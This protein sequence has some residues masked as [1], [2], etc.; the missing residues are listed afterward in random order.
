[1]TTPHDDSDPLS[2]VVPLRRRS[3]QPEPRDALEA[4]IM[5]LELC[6]A[7]ICADV[8]VLASVLSQQLEQRVVED[9]ANL[10]PDRRS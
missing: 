1:M 7:Q 4:R 9:E 8:A 3:A 6:F 2:N 10:K 5:R